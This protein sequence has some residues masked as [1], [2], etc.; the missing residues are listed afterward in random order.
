MKPSL[1]L[2]EDGNELSEGNRTVEK[3]YINIK[4]NLLFCRPPEEVLPVRRFLYM[5]GQTLRENSMFYLFA[6]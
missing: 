6:L 5:N 2:L 3:S 4:L 1:L